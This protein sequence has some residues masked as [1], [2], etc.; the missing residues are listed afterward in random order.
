MY[1]LGRTVFGLSHKDP[2]FEQ[3]LGQL[4]THC[5]DS[6]F[7][8]DLVY[9]LRLGWN[10]DL[11][12]L[13]NQLVESHKRCSRLCA[14]SLVSADG[15]KVLISGG[16]D[17]GKT[18]LAL[19]LVFGHGWK[20][21]SEHSTLLDMERNEIVNF[22]APFRLK[23]GIRD[24]LENVSIS[25]PQFI[26]H[27][28]LPVKE[29]HSAKD[30]NGPFDVVVH[31]EGEP[32]TALDCSSMNVAQYVRKILP[33]SNLLASP[34]NV[35]RFR[36]YLTDCCYQFMGGS[37]KERI[38]KVLQICELEKTAVP[39]GSA[40]ETGSAGVP[41]VMKETATAAKQQTI[42]INDTEWTRCLSWL[43]NTI[44]VPPSTPVTKAGLQDDLLVS[45]MGPVDGRRLDISNTGP[46][47]GG[48][49]ALSRGAAPTL[50]V[51]DRL[52][53]S[54]IWIDHRAFVRAI[55][56]EQMVL[57]LHTR[58]GMRVIASTD[59]SFVHDV[60]LQFG[61]LYVVSTGTNEVVQL[62]LSGKILRRWKFPGEAD[63]R[64]LNCMDLWNGRYVVSCFGRFEK[65]GAY[66]QNGAGEGVVFDLE[67]DE[68]IWDG[69]HFPHTPRMDDG[70]Q[71][72]CDSGS[73]RLLIRDCDNTKVREVYFPGSFTRGI[74]FGPKCIYVGLS[75]IRDA[76]RG[77]SV[78][79]IPNARIA[80]LDRTTFELIDEV[81]VP[82]LEIYDIMVVTPDVDAFP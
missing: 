32:G 65:P 42:E 17:T 79:S 33:I 15:Q 61:Q 70:R 34:E 21:I 53:S 46:V 59:C 55:S 75:C 80:I 58:E 9:D 20:V 57:H 18:T 72:V 51:V 16:A 66:P 19:A 23:K 4:L 25:L 13:L 7:E 36:A 77:Q 5:T 12:E 50:R 71:F 64:H 14:A 45:I 43:S 68:T 22:T 10:F 11:N 62:S 54:G 37:I 82:G 27:D 39:K 31:L 52:P 48:L 30:C 35:D 26:L 47:F 76:I 2:S 49:L 1:K 60:R 73:S 24:V 44:L 29:E 41:G 63:S 3:V 69:L 6:H 67:T 78:P 56:C 74:A 81:N 28:F 40:V 38:E 8:C